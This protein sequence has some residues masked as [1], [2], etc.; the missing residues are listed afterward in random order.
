[1]KQQIKMYAS[2][3]ESDDKRYQLQNDRNLRD[4]DW[5]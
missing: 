1:M 3:K 4:T 2:F 5:M